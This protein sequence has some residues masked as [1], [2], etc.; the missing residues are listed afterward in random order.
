MV[1]YKFYR[2]VYRIAAPVICF[3]RPVNVIGRENMIK[4]AAMVC[5]NHS[6]L[7]DPFLVAIPFGYNDPVHVIAKIELYKNP[8]VSWF[9]KKMGM[10]SVDRSINDIGSIKASLDYLKKGEK[11]IIFPEGTRSSEYDMHAAKSGAVKLAE[12]AGVP[13]IPVFVPRIKPFFKKSNII[14]GEPYCI[15]KQKEKRHADDYAKLSEEL[16]VKIQD[17][18]PEGKPT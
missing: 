2:F 7:I 8:I 3:F 11:V 4:G 14:Y 16:M 17:L 12:R 6:A 15:E 10:I 5:S 1:D 9:L 18:D 13:I